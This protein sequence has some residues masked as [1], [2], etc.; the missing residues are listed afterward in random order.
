MIDSTKPYPS[1]TNSVKGKYPFKIGTTSFIYRDDYIPNVSRLGGFLD[2]IELLV[3]ESDPVEMLFPQPVIAELAGLA[4]TMKLSYNIHLPTDISISDP[5][6]AQQKL[7][8]ETLVKVIRR[9]SPLCPTTHSLHIPYN[10]DTYEEYKIK[11]WQDIVYRNLVQILNA[12]IAADKI[13]IETLDYPLELVV[14]IVADLGLTLCLDIG[15]LLIHGHDCPT[16][17]NRYGELTSIIH[18]HGV[19]NNRDHVALDRLPMDFMVS[20]LQSLHG[21]TGSVSLEVFSFKHLQ[22]SLQYVDRCWQKMI[23]DNLDSNVD[24]Q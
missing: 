6:S 24:N 12:G 22:K 7:A 20:I 2:E 23:T 21:F 15:H 1:L 3:F 5:D 18:L 16:M 10:E 4:E 14:E 9:M 17:I 19:E 13:S 8:V 11:R